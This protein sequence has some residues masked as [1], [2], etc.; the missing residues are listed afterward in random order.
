M[1]V[2]KSTIIGILL[3]I[4]AILIIV[5]CSGFVG[6]HNATSY[7]SGFWVA[8]P[9]F[10]KSSGLS[11]A[12]VLFEPKASDGTMTGFLTMMSADKSNSVV[13]NQKI[14]M[15]RL[16][17][18]KDGDNIYILKNV[19][20]SYSNSSVMPTKLNINL[21]INSGIM[22]MSDN[23]KLYAVFIKDNEATSMV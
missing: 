16:N 9:E 22:A 4:I 17:P 2:N 10:L 20:I 7:M 14:T 21:D 23:E 3:V 13:S 12:Y 15:T 18:N 5:I 8:E 11:A 6:Q 1:P 19:N